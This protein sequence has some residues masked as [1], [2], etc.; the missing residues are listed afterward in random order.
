MESS[1]VHWDK[2]VERL[3]LRTVCYAVNQEGPTENLRSGYLPKLAFAAI[4]DLKNGRVAQL[5]RAHGSH[6]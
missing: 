3:N 4:M 2:W 6:P 5:V 1:R